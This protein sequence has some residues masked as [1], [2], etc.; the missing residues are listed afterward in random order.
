MA[1]FALKR[2]RRRHSVI[3]VVSMIDVM[4][5][6]LFFFMVTSSYLN[7]DMVPAL[8]KAD[9]PGAPSTAPATPST[10]LMIRIAADGGAMI[11]GQSLDSTH[12]TALLK[13]RLAEDPLTPIVLFPSGAAHLQDLI[14]VMDTVTKS[15]ANRVRVI[16]IEAAK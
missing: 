12:L 1:G 8:Q 11:G 4:M 3:S 13:T 2:P 10:T 14:A 16:R 5:I 6:L 7:L 15:G 9:D